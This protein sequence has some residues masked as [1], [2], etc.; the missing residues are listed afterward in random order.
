VSYF[1]LRIIIIF[2]ETIKD[3]DN[4][5]GLRPPIRRLNLRP[6]E[7]PKMAPPSQLEARWCIFPP[8]A[9]APT[10]GDPQVL[11][12]NHR[13]IVRVDWERHAPLFAVQTPE[14]AYFVALHRVDTRRAVLRPA[15]V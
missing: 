15:D 5:H 8:T 14:R 11:G 7:P 1:T 10:L 2:M 12:P 6:L 13:N 4:Q 3:L 9:R